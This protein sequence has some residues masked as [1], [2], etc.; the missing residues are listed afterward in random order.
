M[1]LGKIVT[2]RGIGSVEGGGTLQSKEGEIVHCSIDIEIDP[3]DSGLKAVCDFLTVCGAP[4]GSK[5][6]LTRDGKKIEI[7]FGDVEGIGIYLNGTDLPDEVYQSSDINVVMETIDQLV[8][9]VCVMKSYWR[10]PTET[11]LYLYGRSA[12][13]LKERTAAFIAEY[14]LCQKCRVVQ[15]A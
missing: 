1:P 5:L 2:E 4:K 6:Q 10:G 14:P 8:A 7:P 11:A 3:S 15:I 12:S 9:D 13:E